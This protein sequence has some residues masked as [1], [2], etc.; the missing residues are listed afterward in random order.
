M[1]RLVRFI[2]GKWDLV[3]FWAG[4]LGVVFGAGIAVERYQIFPHDLIRHASAAA[5][6]WRVN[7]RHYLQI[8]SK[9]LRPSPRT[10][11]GVTRHDRAA[12]SPGHTFLTLYRDNRFG[13]LLIDMEGRILHRWDIA[14][15]DAFPEPRHLEVAPPDYD[16]VLHGAAL[17]PDGDVILNMEGVGAVRLD[18]CSRLVWRLPVMTHHSVEH[19]PSGETLIAADRLYHAATP[20]FPRLAP[21]PEGHFIDNLVLRLRPDGSVARET[22]VLDVLYE[23]GWAALLFAGEDPTIRT[24]QPTH[25]NDI[26]VLRE[27]MA[28]AFPRFRA[29]DVMLS[30]RNLNT[31]MVVDGQTWRIK[32]T[33]TGPFLY[34]H[35]PD[36]M[37]N[38]NILLF[39]NRRTGGRPQLGY[40]R[41]IEIDPDTREIV[42]SY[43]GTDEEPFYTDIRGMQ[44]LL[45]NGNV[46][47][48]E[49]QRGRVFEVARESDNR[50]VWEY[51]NLARDGFAGLITGAERVAPERLTF[52]GTSCD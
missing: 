39:D 36:F 8:R 41:I 14:F 40:S 27:D 44:Q 24:A 46:L 15:S 29:G 16:V 1:Q 51:V 3:L 4:L 42:W 9:H 7:W 20:H 23:S 12:A 19:L 6:D 38:G 48:V 31:I 18:R 22:S 35:D 52:L 26:E 49:A 32:W 33:M 30:I 11:G 2:R 28:A 25:L 43:Q 17:L 47:V 34:Q 45:P 37:P 10:E 50:I 13:A 21:G 5:Q